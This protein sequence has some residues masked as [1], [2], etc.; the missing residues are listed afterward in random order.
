MWYALE[1][2]E[3]ISEGINKVRDMSCIEIKNKSNEN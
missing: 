1:W 2:N 3:T